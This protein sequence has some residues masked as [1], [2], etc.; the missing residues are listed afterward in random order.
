[1]ISMPRTI[2]V[3]DVPDLAEQVR[4]LGFLTPDAAAHLDAIEQARFVLIRMDQG[5][6]WRCGRCGGKHSVPDIGPVLTRMCIPRPW[7]G[8]AEGL[9]AYYQHLG[10]RSADLSP[11]QRRR[12]STIAGALPDLAT[13]HPQAA[14]ALKTRPNDLDYVGWMIGSIVEISEQDARRYAALINGRAY[15]EVVRL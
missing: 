9:Y 7:R 11:E 8:I 1:M 15:R 3:A 5:E 14:R 13:R 10:A 4:A 12:A 6:Y 2:P